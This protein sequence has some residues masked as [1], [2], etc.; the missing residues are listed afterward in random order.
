MEAVRG[1]FTTP[2]LGVYHH[3]RHIRMQ[4]TA[5]TALSMVHVSLPANLQGQEEQVRA[6]RFGIAK[7]ISLR[8]QG[9][10]TELLLPPSV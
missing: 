10:A 7:Y 8:H 3:L 9:T 4:M 5:I 6:P 2:I 1:Y